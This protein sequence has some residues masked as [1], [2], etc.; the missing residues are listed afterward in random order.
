MG[1][2]IGLNRM[3][4]NKIKQQEEYG[5]GQSKRNID[6]EAISKFGENADRFVLIN[7]EGNVV[8]A[9]DQPISIC[10]QDTFVGKRDIIYKVEGNEVRQHMRREDFGF[11]HARAIDRR[12]MYYYSRDKEKGTLVDL[13]E[14]SIIDKCKLAVY[15]VSSVWRLLFVIK[16]D[17]TVVYSSFRAKCIKA[18]TELPGNVSEWQE[19][20]NV[21]LNEENNI[22]S[23][24]KSEIHFI[25]NARKYRVDDDYTDE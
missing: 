1:D 25:D 2:K 3:T 9:S 21:Q 15:E 22:V 18:I 24:N 16:A 6:K 11:T 8:Y 4:K 23:V 20:F 14:D 5:I 13:D 10:N 7:T 19:N 12:L 17:K